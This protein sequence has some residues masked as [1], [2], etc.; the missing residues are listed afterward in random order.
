MGTQVLTS[1]SLENVGC[2][3]LHKTTSLRRASPMPPV[4]FL[5]RR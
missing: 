4:P 2:V 1:H 5:V 3:A